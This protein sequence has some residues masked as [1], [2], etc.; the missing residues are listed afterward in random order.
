MR[1]IFAVVPPI[2]KDMA[3]VRSRSTAI[4]VAKIRSVETTV[5]LCFQLKQT[6]GSYALMADSYFQHTDFLQC[7]KVGLSFTCA[8]CCS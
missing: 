8:M 2:S 4:A 5:Q 3:C 6:V 1:Q 7:C